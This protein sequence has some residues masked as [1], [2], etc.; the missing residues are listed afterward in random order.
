LWGASLA[1]AH[2]QLGHIQEAELSLDAFG[3][4]CK[5]NIQMIQHPYSNPEVAEIFA[6][7]LLKAGC[8]RFRP[9]SYMFFENNK[10]TENQLKD[11]LSG[12]DVTVESIIPWLSSETIES[13]IEGDLLCFRWFEIPICGSI[14]NSINNKYRQIPEYFYLNDI[15][16]FPFYVAE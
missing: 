7:G 14:F 11:L 13:W 1:V 5:L 10:L 12:H 8:S 2:A 15:W 6:E 9:E 16:A 3:F 4:P